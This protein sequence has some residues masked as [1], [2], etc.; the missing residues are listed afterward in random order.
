MSSCNV[1][2]K[3]GDESSR[4]KHTTLTSCVLFTK[5]YYGLPRSHS[6]HQT[7]VWSAANKKHVFPL[8]AERPLPASD[9]SLPPAAA[10]HELAESW[11]AFV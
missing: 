11:F 1:K 3:N 2:N 4:D 8:H 5:P 7:I 10:D 6:F 9:A